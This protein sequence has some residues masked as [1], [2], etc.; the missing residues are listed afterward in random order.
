M[1][2]M[3]I[4]RP[5]LVVSTLPPSQIERL[6]TL[7][8]DPK[9]VSEKAKEE[10]GNMAAGNHQAL[11]TSAT[12]KYLT[13]S[14]F[15]NGILMAN[16]MP[17]KYQSFAIQMLRR[18]QEEYG[19]QT[20][21]EKATAEVVTINFIQILDLSQKMK[22]VCEYSGTRIGQG[23]MAILSKELDRANRHYLESLQVLKRLKQ[24]P[25]QVNI[26]ANIGQNQVIQTKNG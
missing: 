26:N 21:S 3:T 5:T 7:E 10:L 9:R 1:D 22:N 4:Q 2:S 24:A 25:L 14:E 20:A 13:L 6:I 8:I 15:E 23:C 19:C 16:T 11:S 18:L 12:Y 17:E